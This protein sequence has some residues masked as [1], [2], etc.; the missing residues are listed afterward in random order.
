VARHADTHHDQPACP[1]G[2]GD[3]RA[4]RTTMAPNGLLRTL[5]STSTDECSEPTG[6]RFTPKAM[7]A[8]IIMRF[9]SAT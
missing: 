4:K 2:D 6:Y 3:D 1:D 7:P 8:M 5:R 9:D